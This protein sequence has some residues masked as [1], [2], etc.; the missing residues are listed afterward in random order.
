MNA[1]D[2][3]IPSFLLIIFV[4][5]IYKRVDIFEAFVEG[6]TENLKVAVSI[7]PSLIALMTCVGMLRSCG[8]LDVLAVLVSPATNLIGFPSQCVP[9]AILRPI[10]GSGATAMLVS[11]LKENHPDSFVG[12]VASVLCASTETTFYTIAVYYGAAKIKG[13]KK[14]IA[15]ALLADFAGFIFSALTVRLIMG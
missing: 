1:T 10:S 7:L 4:H 12:R 2:F 13:S 8:I 11:I 15:A 14:T 9:L 6:A 3:I 5:A